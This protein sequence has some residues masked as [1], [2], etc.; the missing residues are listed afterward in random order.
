[1]EASVVTFGKYLNNIKYFI[2]R[3]KQKRCLFSAVLQF[4]WYRPRVHIYFSSC[5]FETRSFHVDTCALSRYTIIEHSTGTKDAD[6][7]GN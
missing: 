5:Q 7:D 1:M 3:L 2:S 6:S 4:L